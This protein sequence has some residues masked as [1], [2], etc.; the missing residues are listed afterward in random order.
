MPNSF[1]DF[2]ADRRDSEI[3][4]LSGALIHEEDALGGVEQHD[5][6]DHPAENGAKLAAFGFEMGESAGQ[7]FAG[8]VHGAS[9]IGDR[10]IAAGIDS[11]VEFSGAQPTY[12]ARE[13]VDRARLY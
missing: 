5:A 7:F 1:P 10:R 13:I 3:E 12:R 2:L 6:L 11:Q 4:Q 8:R 9:Q